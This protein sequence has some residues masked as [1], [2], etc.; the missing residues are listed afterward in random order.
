M[1]FDVIQDVL[2]D[3]R[4]GRADRLREACFDELLSLFAAD[5]LGSDDGREN[6]CRGERKYRKERNG[7]R[8]PRIVMSGPLLSDMSREN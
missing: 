4:S 2:C 8:G 6:E 5:E 1:K 7:R 3:L